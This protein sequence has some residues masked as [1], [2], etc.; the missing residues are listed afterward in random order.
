MSNRTEADISAQAELQLSHLAQIEALTKPGLSDRNR[1][2]LFAEVAGFNVHELW[3]A[4]HIL[5][6]CS[7]AR[8]AWGQGDAQRS[9]F[10]SLPG[11][12]CPVEKNLSGVPHDIPDDWC[13]TAA[14]LE[15]FSRIQIERRFPTS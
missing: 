2:D 7:P 12:R 11:C 1:L 3:V 15:P 10:A 6:D 13:P 5:Y 4:H 14:E 9:L 8:A